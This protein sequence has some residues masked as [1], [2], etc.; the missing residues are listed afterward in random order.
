MNIPMRDPMMQ[1]ARAD[2]QLDL[3]MTVHMG[4]PGWLTGELRT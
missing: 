2:Q 4:E 1:N 3:P